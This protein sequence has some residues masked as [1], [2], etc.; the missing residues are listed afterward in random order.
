MAKIHFDSFNDFYRF[1]R[2]VKA[3]EPK[4]YKPKK[5]STKKKAKE[6]KE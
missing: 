2:G 5:K 6:E 3:R 4:E 1:N